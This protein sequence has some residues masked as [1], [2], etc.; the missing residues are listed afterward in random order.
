MADNQIAVLALGVTALIALANLI[1][2]VAA[3]RNSRIAAQE[4]RLTRRPLLRVDWTASLGN[5]ALELDGIIREILVDVVQRLDLRLQALDFTLPVGDCLYYDTHELP[6]GCILRRSTL[7]A[8][9]SAFQWGSD[10]SPTSVQRPD[11]AR[12]SQ[13]RWVG[14]PTMVTK[15]PRER[16]RPRRSL[17]RRQL[18]PAA[19]TGRPG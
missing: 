16:V 10:S 17:V 18:Q 9:P 7:W 5:R 6:R 13:L 15:S 12:R 19:G 4:F 14:T 8:R 1:T 11:G 3:A 2:A